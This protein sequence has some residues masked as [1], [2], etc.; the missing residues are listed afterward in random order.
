M[1]SCLGIYSDWM[2]QISAIEKLKEMNY[3]NK[4]TNVGK[5]YGNIGRDCVDM[6]DKFA[7]VYSEAGRRPEAL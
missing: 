6:A 3:L 5:T 7:L 4:P 1:D 2:S